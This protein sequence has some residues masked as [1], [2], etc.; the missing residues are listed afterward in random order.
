MRTWGSHDT[1]GLVNWRHLGLS[2]LAL[3]PELKGFH[4]KLTTESE[5]VLKIAIFV[6]FFFF[7]CILNRF[8]G[9]KAIRSLGLSGCGS[10]AL[11]NKRGTNISNLLWVI[12][13]Y[14]P[15]P[16]KFNEAATKS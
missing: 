4:H 1:C 16:P 3:H 10:C 14:H 5:S 12:L 6:G 11:P 8:P 9:F 13:S 15:T 2:Y 7:F